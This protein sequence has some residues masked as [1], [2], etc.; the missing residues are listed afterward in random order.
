MIY[1][2][3]Q[4][5]S[6]LDAILG[7][8]SVSGGSSCIQAIFTLTESVRLGDQSDV[9]V[10]K[11]GGIQDDCSHDVRSLV[12]FTDKDTQWVRS[13]EAAPPTLITWSLRCLRGLEPS[14]GTQQM[15][16]LR[17]RRWPQTEHRETQASLVFLW[18]LWQ[19]TIYVIFMAFEYICV[20]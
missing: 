12:R 9:E 13:R 8:D 6:F 10:D 14:A 15:I 3:F 17:L 2:T 20:F 7:T 18:G 1:I 4:F 19:L 11:E 5:F 16:T